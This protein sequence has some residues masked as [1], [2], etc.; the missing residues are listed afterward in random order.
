M[1]RFLGNDNTFNRIMT[2]YLGKSVPIPPPANIPALP[3]ATE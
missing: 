1:T 3:E 2:H